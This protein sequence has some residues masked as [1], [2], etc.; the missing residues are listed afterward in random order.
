MQLYRYI[1]LDNK[2]Y[3]VAADTYTMK[4]Q[5]AYSSQLVSNVVRL[6]FIDNGPGIRVYD[7]TLILKTWNPTDQPYLDGITETWNQQM[8]DLENSYASVVGKPLQFQDP[9]G[10]SP[11]PA[12]NY[13]V[14]FTNYDLN[15]P[16]YSTPQTPIMLANIEVTEATQTYN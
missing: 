2:K 15:V 9:L 16:R 3:V 11:G 4:W 10:R 1:I 12:S 8:A 6:N 5:R 13:G 14:Y 7:G